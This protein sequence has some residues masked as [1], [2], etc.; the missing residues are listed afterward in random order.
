MTRVSPLFGFMPY[1]APELLDAGRPNL[2]RALVVASTMGALVFALLG[3]LRIAHPE[4]TATPHAPSVDIC[5]CDT[6]PPPSLLP[7]HHDAPPAPTATSTSSSIDD[8]VPDALMKPGEPTF[9][10]PDVTN[11]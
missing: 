8:I 11:S 3:L 7:E 6:P 9:A 10:M 1:G 5:L 4:L 2:A